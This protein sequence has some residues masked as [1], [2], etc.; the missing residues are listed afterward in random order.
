MGADPRTRRRFTAAQAGVVSGLGTGLGVLAGLALGWVLVTAERY[1]WELP[2]PTWQVS[3]P[4]ATVLATLVAVPLLAV[5]VGYAAARSRL[6]V[7][8]RLAG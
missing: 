2:D 4:W 7:V 5:A 6:P 1:R 3:V 8:R